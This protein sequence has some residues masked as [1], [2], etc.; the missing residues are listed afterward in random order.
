MTTIHTA[1]PAGRDVLQ[2]VAADTPE[3]LILDA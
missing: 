3:P 1:I 2:I